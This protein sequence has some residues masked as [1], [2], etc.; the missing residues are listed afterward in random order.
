MSRIS[1]LQP[2]KASADAKEIFNQLKAKI[3]MVP[4][5]F[6]N[7]GNS[8]AVLKGF[9][10]FSEVANQT[11]LTP[12]LR[13]QI[14][15]VVA[16]TNHCNYCLS[17]HTAMAGGIGIPSQ[18]IIQAR[19]GQASDPKTQAILKFAKNVV[20]KRGNVANQDIAALK[21]ANI[22]DKELVEV[23]YVIIV[24]MFTNYFNLITDPKFDFPVAPELN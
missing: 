1:T 6:L 24:N 11:S 7:M 18:E 12:K 15:L 13:E 2:E 23:I 21:A 22:S 19:N 17:A 9:L 8:P 10:N 20:E 16:Q 3:G 5:I 14:A 4:N